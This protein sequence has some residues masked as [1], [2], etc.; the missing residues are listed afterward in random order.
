MNKAG[1]SVLIALIFVVAPHPRAETASTSPSYRLEPT[2][3]DAAGPRVASSGHVVTGALAQPATVGTSSAP[4]FVLQSGFFGFIGTGLV[5]VVLSANRTAGQPQSVDLAW[6]GNDAPYDLYR[7]EA[8]A[9][10]YASV[11]ATTS[12]NA[13]TDAGA[14]ASGLTCYSVLATAPGPAPPPPPVP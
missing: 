10:V 7:S 1:S 13:Y 2:T 12:N 9:T 8:C 6:S 5:P 4:H 3:F 11:Y 14:P